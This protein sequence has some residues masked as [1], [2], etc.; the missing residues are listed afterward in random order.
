M[1]ASKVWLFRVTGPSFPGDWWGTT[2]GDTK[3]DALARVRRRMRQKLF[4]EHGE[5]DHTRSGG[6][7]V[8]L[9]EHDFFTVAEGY[10]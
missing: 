10:L 3:A 7:V 8:E 2:D 5:G 4:S 6:L 9:W 1:S